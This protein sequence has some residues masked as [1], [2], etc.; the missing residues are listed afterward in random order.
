MS[1]LIKKENHSNFTFQ[2]MNYSL[3]LNLFK[4]LKITN[5]YI[6]CIFMDTVYF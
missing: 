3:S 6:A 1:N 2:V 4:I 5:V